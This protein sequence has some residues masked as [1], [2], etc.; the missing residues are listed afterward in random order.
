MGHHV[1]GRERIPVLARFP[2]GPHLWND[3]DRLRVG[4]IAGHL[5]RAHQL[6]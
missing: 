5:G 6:V 4:D 2:G 1:T 3:L